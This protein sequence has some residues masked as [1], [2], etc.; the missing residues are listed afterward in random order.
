M[1]FYQ[2]I[3]IIYYMEIDIKERKRMKNM[4]EEEK[5]NIIME[6]MKENGKMD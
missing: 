4:K 3:R 6:N 1:N 5:W 2:I